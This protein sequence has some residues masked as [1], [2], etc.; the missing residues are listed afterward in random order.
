MTWQLPVLLRN[1][2]N[3]AAAQRAVDRAKR[4]SEFRG[5]EE[6][7]QLRRRRFELRGEGLF[8]SLMKLRMKMK[9]KIEGE[10]R[11]MKGVYSRV[12]VLSGELS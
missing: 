7:F 4:K 2:D 3:R 6:H 5:R 8:G 1:V 10:Q 12:L 11:K 9:W